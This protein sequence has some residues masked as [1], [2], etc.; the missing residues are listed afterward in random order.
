MGQGNIFTSICLSTGWRGVSVWGSL[1]RGVSVQ[2]EALTR[3]EVSDQ[4]VSVWG[5]SVQGGYLSGLFSVTET[6]VTVEDRAVRIILECILVF[7]FFPVGHQVALWL[8][9]SMDTHP[10]KTVFHTCWS[11]DDSEDIQ[12]RHVVYKLPTYLAYRYFCL[13]SLCFYYRPQTKFAKVMFLHLSVILFTGWGACMAGGVR[14]SPCVARGRGCMHGRGA[15]VAGGGMHGRGAGGMCS[16]GCAW[17]G[18][19]HGPPPHA[20][21]VRILLE[22]ILVYV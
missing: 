21:A 16:G 11:C 10:D 8:T 15:C 4:G 13:F 12:I 19:M 14:S 2:W 17:Q 1:S 7:L 20:R 9:V 6:P 3:G 22:C 18:G 5:V